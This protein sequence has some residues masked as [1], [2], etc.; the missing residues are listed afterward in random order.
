MAHRSVLVV[1]SFREETAQRVREAAAFAGT[2]AEFH[3]QCA[4]AVAPLGD[5]GPLAVVVRMD[6]PGAADLCA[7]VRTQARLADVPVFGVAPER[8]DIAF[9]EL[10][11]WGGD[12][13]VSLWSPQP[14]TRRLRPLVG[15]T[16]APR[17]EGQGCA[18]VAGADPRWRSVMGRSLYSGG[19][20]VRFASTAAEL[21]TDS[22]GPSV[23]LVVA[24]DDVCE[25]GAARCAV[26]ARSS[27][28]EAAWVV[29]VPPK[30]MAA[31]IAAASAQSRVS[32]ADGY[33]PP[34]N[35]LFLANELLGRGGEDKRASARLLY[36]T[37]VAF[38]GAGRDEDE[39][40]FSYN[41]SAAGVY[42]RSL[43]PLDQ[44]QDVWLE[45]W[46]P[47]SERRVRL[48]GTVA[49]K[50]PFGSGERA[51]VP[52]GFGVKITD[53]LGGDLERWR[54]GYHAFSDSLLGARAPAPSAP[55][56]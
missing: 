7:H 10:F 21:L 44:G 56:V 14:L 32:I 37:R 18:V 42:V 13:L 28:A 24:S 22:L 40:G 3:T 8:T 26:R 51:T 43:A 33:A 45:M 50:R 36:G 16:I 4:D 53:G 5:P 55:E 52:A 41:V 19:F 27:G 12:D 17:G 48:A 9:T 6:A 38:R 39:T 23:R 47:R 2:T 1:G 20:S 29:V 49:W 11:S 35:V 25:E 34:E 30:R 31:A 54:Q 15:R 46:A